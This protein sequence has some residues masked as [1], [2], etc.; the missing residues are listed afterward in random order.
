MTETQ[1]K[2]RAVPVSLDEPAHDTALT[3]EVWVVSDRPKSPSSQGF[4][5][6]A[7]LCHL[8]RAEP[9]KALCMEQTDQSP[10]FDLHSVER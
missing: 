9:E 6:A 7:F 1:R 10:L 5:C 2:A 4:D 3:E 8:E